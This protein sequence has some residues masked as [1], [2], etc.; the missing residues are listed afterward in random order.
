[1]VHELVMISFILSMTF[2]LWLLVLWLPI[3][4][5]QSCHCYCNEVP[6]LLNQCHVPDGDRELRYKTNLDPL[7]VQE[8]CK[9]SCCQE[10]TATQ[11]CFHEN[12]VG[13]S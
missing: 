9:D 4:R 10:T 8:Y 2:A 12:A 11:L 6:G 3:Y 13:K 7:A 1:M 5:N